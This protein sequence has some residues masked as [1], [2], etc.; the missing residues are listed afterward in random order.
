MHKYG[1]TSI[2]SI[3]GLNWGIQPKHYEKLS[4]EKKLKLRVSNGIMIFSDEDYKE[5]INKIIELRDKYKSEYFK[6]TT[7][8]LLGDGVVEGNTANL[9]SPYEI[10]AGKGDNYYGEFLWDQDTLKNVIKE[11]NENKF[12]IQVHSVGDGS[13]HKMLKA[14][15]ELDKLNPTLYKNS[16][17]SL[18][19]LQLVAKDDIKR[20]EKLN[21]IAS[22]QPYWHLKGPGW[23]D[24]VDYNLLGERAENEYPL[25]SF[26]DKNVLV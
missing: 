1:I 11:S 2:L 16:R 24:V 7:V 18:T 8:K 25:K 9:L 26:I 14:I 20:F 4:K 21:V 13:T 22:V 5:Q 10:G 19:H 12:S 6:T 15:E 23:W 3:S 17:N